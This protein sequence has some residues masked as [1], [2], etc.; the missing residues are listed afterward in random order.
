MQL[1]VLERS[2]HRAPNGAGAGLVNMG[3]T[4]YMNSVLQ[5]LAHLPPLANI[6]HAQVSSGSKLAS[7]SW[8]DPHRSRVWFTAA[9]VTA[10]A[11]QAQRQAQQQPYSNNTRH[12]SSLQTQQMSLHHPCLNND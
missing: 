2:W 8:G 11:V 3:N 12:I 6:V 10:P 7:G 4:C 5:C 9:I 1:P